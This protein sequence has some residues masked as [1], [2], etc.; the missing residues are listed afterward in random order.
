MSQ[1]STD[2]VSLLNQ[3]DICNFKSELLRGMLFIFVFIA[4]TSYQKKISIQILNYIFSSQKQVK[5]MFKQQTMI[6]Q[7]F[8]EN[9]NR[10]YRNLHNLPTFQKMSDLGN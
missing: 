9:H 3:E 4:P 8:I 7:H 1:N 2:N 6:Q 5:R 10:D